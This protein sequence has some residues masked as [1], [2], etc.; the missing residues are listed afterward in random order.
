MA[1]RL[2][3]APPAKPAVAPHLPAWSTAPENR[4]RRAVPRSPTNSVCANQL[5]QAE[6][7]L[8]R[9]ELAAPPGRNAVEL[10][11]GALE[12]DPANTLAKAGLVRVADRL[13]SAAERALTAGNP[14]DAKTHGRRR[15]NAHARHGA[16]RVPDDADRDGARACGA[17]THATTPTCST[18]RQRARPTCGSRTRA[19]AAAR[20][21]SPPRTTRASISRPRARSFPTIRRVT[22]TDRVAAARNCSI[23]RQRRGHGRQRRR[24]RALAGERRRRRRA[25]QRNGRH[26]PL[27][28]G[29]A[30]RRA[31]RARSKRLAQ[32]FTTALSANNLL[33]PADRNAKAYLLALIEADSGNPVVTTARA[34]LGNALRKE[35]RG[36]LGARRSRRGRHAWLNEAQH[37]RTLGQRHRTPPSAISAARARQAA[38]RHRWSVRIR[39]NASNTS[40]RSFRPSTRNR[41]MIG[42][43]ELEF[44]VRADGSTG[45]IVVTNSNPRRTF[46]SAAIAAVSRVALQ[47]GRARRQAGR[48]TRRRPHPLLGRIDGRA[49]HTTLPD[50]RERRQVRGWL[51]HAVGT[52]WP[53]DSIIIMDWTS[54]GRVRTAMTVRDYDIVM[55][56]LAFDE[57]IEEPT[58]D[59]LRLD[60][61][62]AQPAGLSR[63]DHPRRRR[64]R[65]RRGPHAA[66]RRGRLSTEAAADAAAP[67]AL[68]QAHAAR[69]REGSAAPRRTRRAG[70]P[71]GR[72]EKAGETADEQAGVEPSP[73]SRPHAGAAIATAAAPTQYGARSSR[74]GPRPLRRPRRPPAATALRRDC[75]GDRATDPRR[76]A[77]RVSGSGRRFDARRKQGSRSPSRRA[78]TRFRATR[79]CRRSASPRP[80]RSTSRSP[81]TSGTTSR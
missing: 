11:R 40:R 65:A 76:L 66:P 45:D 71:E 50:R 17:D 4:R 59:S 75:S 32:S 8:Q 51:Q 48:T 49:A 42:W 57:G 23:A 74:S 41:G 72:S 5:A 34:S 29:H 36:A 21:S 43:V 9:G 53:A 80:R 14:E 46:D 61:Q 47:A 28:A 13:L 56:A 6:A 52:G 54:F 31:R 7:A 62:A 20:S 77:A 10:F 44:T 73:A 55:L 37:D 79:S 70:R 69:H 60:P 12:L 26:P 81:K 78:L 67:A 22:E 16:R 58:T 63:N 68:D 33:Q 2:R 3:Q 27:A 64:Q 19:C 24:N 35:L 15:R 18:S 39:C 25:A 38:Q 30:D 1:E